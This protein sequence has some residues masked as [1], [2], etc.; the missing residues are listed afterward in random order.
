M[1]AE[2]DEMDLG[3]TEDKTKLIY[4][5]P[6]KIR[7]GATHLR[8]L[9]GSFDKVG[10]GLKGVDSSALKGQAADTFRGSVSIEPPRWFKAADAFE[11]AAAAL[12]P[13]RGRGLQGLPRSV[14]KAVGSSPGFIAGI[15][16]GLAALGEG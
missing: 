5:S 2:V 8:N 15:R 9:Q 16:K 3:Q 12:V 14:E 11:K 1:G 6:S 7:A 4:G 13:S 10:G